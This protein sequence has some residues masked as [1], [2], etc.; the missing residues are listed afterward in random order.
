ME[1]FIKTTNEI[2]HDAVDN[3]IRAK[4]TLIC[5]DRLDFLNLSRARTLAE[6]GFGPAAVTLGR[7]GRN[8]LPVKL[9][10]PDRPFEPGRSPNSNRQIF[11]IRF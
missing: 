6:T 8:Q 2:K 3:K 4:G 1:I 7:G 10:R 5:P 11:V 9:A